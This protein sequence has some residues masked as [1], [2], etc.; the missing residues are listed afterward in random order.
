M[1]P[2]DGSRPADAPAFDAASRTRLPMI[3]CDVHHALRA[4]AALDPYLSQQWR[5]HL[6]TY[7]LRTPGPFLGSPA[8]PKAAPAL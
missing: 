4:P 8:Y 6:A 7:G 3:D 2:D 5:T 1:T